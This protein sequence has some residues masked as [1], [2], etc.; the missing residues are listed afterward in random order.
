MLTLIDLKRVT[1]AVRLELDL[2]V[3]VD[4]LRILPGSNGEQVKLLVAKS[5]S[6]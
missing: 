3:S 4:R 5:S 6:S 1:L 2:G